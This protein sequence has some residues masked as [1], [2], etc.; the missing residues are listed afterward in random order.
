MEGRKYHPRTPV[1]MDFKGP[2]GFLNSVGVCPAWA[3]GIYEE[4]E[5]WLKG[6]YFPLGAI[7]DGIWCEKCLSKGFYNWVPMLYRDPK[8]EAHYRVCGECISRYRKGLI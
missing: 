1:P 6:A 7:D 4:D 3:Y 8:K 2:A 5:D